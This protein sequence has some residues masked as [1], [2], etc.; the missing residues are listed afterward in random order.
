M[1]PL[2]MLGFIVLILFY[3]SYLCKQVLLKRKGINTNR[4]GRGNKLARTFK[5]ETALKLATF[6]MAAVQLIS[7]LVME[8]GYLVLTSPIIRF[9]GISIAFLG[10]GVFIT[11]MVC[12]KTSWRA[13]IDAIQRTSLVKSGIYRISRNP[14]FLGFDLFYIG[15]GLAFSNPVQLM[16]ILLC[17]VVLHLQILEE[18]RFLPTAFGIAYEEYK[19]VTA[20]YFLFF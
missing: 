3:G 5:I 6:S 12:M 20:R 2:N 16:F 1:D 13:G 18:E 4:L 17:V 8:K 15:F 10:T 9:A 7:L 14:A 11:A 19:Q